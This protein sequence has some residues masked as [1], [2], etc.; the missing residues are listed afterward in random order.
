MLLQSPFRFFR[1]IKK[2]HGVLVAEISKDY[3]SE[4]L[5]S[6]SLSKGHFSYITDSSGT[7]IASTA[8]QQIGQ[9]SSL[10]ALGGFFRVD[11]DRLAKG[12]KV[13]RLIKQ[14]KM[15]GTLFMGCRNESH[16][17]LFKSFLLH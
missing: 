6:V 13:W 14:C 3:L 5:K 11:G 2:F 7:V 16:L 12:K 8:G 15:D 17:N 10:H 1:Q 9:T 4:V